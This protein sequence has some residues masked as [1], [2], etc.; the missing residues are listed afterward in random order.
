MCF[1][2]EAA[3]ALKHASVAAA[4]YE[5][6]L[7][8]ADRVAISYPEISLGP[9]SRFLGMVAT[10]TSRSDEAE[11]HFRD[12]AD[13]GS[14]IGARASVAHA[15]RALGELLLQQDGAR[16]EEGHTLLLEAASAYGA[17]GMNA[18]ARAASD[19]SDRLTRSRGA[20]PIR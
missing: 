4:I 2:A 11:R 5:R 20:W 16:F 19:L 1:L 12:A 7:P 18:Y 6:L 17:L 14:R 3:A 9:I 15:K 8:Y 13:L 10:A